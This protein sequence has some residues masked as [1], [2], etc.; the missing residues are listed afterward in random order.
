M[1]LATTHS[2]ATPA[3]RPSSQPNLVRFTTAGCASPDPS[4]CETRVRDDIVLGQPERVPR[5]FPDKPA[6]SERG[7]SN[8]VSARLGAQTATHA[9]KSVRATRGRG[10]PTPTGM[11]APHE[12]CYFAPA[13]SRQQHAF[14]QVP[15]H[16]G[17]RSG[18]RIVRDHDNRFVKVFIQPLKNFE[19][20]GRRMA[21]EI[22]G[23]FVGK[24]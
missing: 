4:A 6:L 10:Q 16:V 21:V 11:S 20:F 22:A 13:L 8:G 24:Q 15:G 9:D 5:I 7:E 23:R 17:V 2:R 12:H 19:N 18:M 14:F 1:L 3:N